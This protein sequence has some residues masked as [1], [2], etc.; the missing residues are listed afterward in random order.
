MNETI[1]TSKQVGKARYTLNINLTPDTEPYNWERTLNSQLLPEDGRVWIP[2]LVPQ[3]LRL[4]LE[5]RVPK[6]PSSE[7]QWGSHPRVPQTVVN[8]EV[9]LK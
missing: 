5:G 3:F 6:T 1:P 4:P 8:K 9:I 2:H 7:S